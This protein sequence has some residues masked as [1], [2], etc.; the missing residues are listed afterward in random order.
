MIR[1]KGVPHQMFTR[2]TQNR[3]QK[4]SLNQGTDVPKNV[5]SIQLN[6][7][8]LGSNNHH[9]PSVLRAGA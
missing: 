1:K 5:W 6:A 4:G 7:L 2:I 9:Q 3:A 8:W